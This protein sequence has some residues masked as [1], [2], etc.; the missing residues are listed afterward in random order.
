MPTLSKLGQLAY[1]SAKIL[2]QIFK[3]HGVLFYLFIHFGFMLRIGLCL[4]L[5]AGSL[6]VLVVLCL[7]T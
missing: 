5:S 6:V 4:G 7:F 3:W 2:F 1:V